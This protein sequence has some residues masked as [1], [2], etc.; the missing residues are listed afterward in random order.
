MKAHHS[1]TGPWRETVSPTGLAEANGHIMNPF[2]L[3][4]NYEQP[5][6]LRV[7]SSWQ[8]ASKWGL[9]RIAAW[10]GILPTNWGSL[11][12]DVLVKFWWNLSPVTP[13]LQPVETLRYRTQKSDAWIP[14]LWKLWDNKMHWY[15]LYLCPWY[16]H[17]GTAPL[18]LR[19]IGYIFS[20]LDL[21]ECWS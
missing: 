18:K 10:K 9:S 3:W 20:L 1:K 19:I 17:T 2:S 6:D 15:W 4:G 14:K 8:L 13:G 12:M 7:D 16:G 11:G 5:Q 21:F